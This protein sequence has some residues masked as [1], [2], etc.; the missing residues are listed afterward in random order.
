MIKLFL[1]RS[2]FVKRV[3]HQMTQRQVPGSGAGDLTPCLRQQDRG[4]RAGRVP[5]LTRKQSLRKELASALLATGLGEP[6][7]AAAHRHS[8]VRQQP[9]LT[10]ADH[11]RTALILLRIRR[12][13]A[14]PALVDLH[15]APIRVLHNDAAAPGHHLVA[16]EDRDSGSSQCPGCLVE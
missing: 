11:P 10:E 1:R 15:R 5:E 6:D 4:L 16:G 9:G 8:T 7:R 12:P 3:P 14:V 13:V 2:V